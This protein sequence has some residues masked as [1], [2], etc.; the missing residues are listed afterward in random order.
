M[1]NIGDRHKQ[2]NTEQVK[3]ALWQ[4]W[5]SSWRQKTIQRPGDNVR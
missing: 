4:V 1:A 5:V 3:V 2:Q